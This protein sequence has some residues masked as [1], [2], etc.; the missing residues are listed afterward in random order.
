MP[1][2]ITAIDRM[3]ELIE[4]CCAI[5]STVHGGAVQ[6]ICQQLVAVTIQARVGLLQPLVVGLQ[7]RP[8]VVKPGLSLSLRGALDLERQGR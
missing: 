3:G 8:A 6:N 5:E 2:L 4:P 1:E 7:C